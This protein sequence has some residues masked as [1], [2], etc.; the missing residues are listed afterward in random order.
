LSLLAAAYD[1][2]ARGGRL[3][4]KGSATIIDAAYNELVYGGQLIAIGAASIAATCSIVLGRSPPL[5]LL[6]IVYLFA[7]AAYTVNKV[8]ETGQDSI[9][10]PERTAYV[11]KRSGFLRSIVP[12]FFLLGL[13]LALL[14]SLLLFLVLL[15]PIVLTVLY[16]IGSDRLVKITGARRF[17]DKLIV[18]NV[19]TSF[20]WA[21][22]PLIA[23]LYFP[24]ISLAPLLIAPFVF[25]RLLS[26]TVFFDIRDIEADTSFGTR[27]IPVVYGVGAANVFMQAADVAAFCYILLVALLG[28]VPYFTLA[29]VVFPVYSFAYRYLA[30]FVDKDVIRDLIADAE[31]VLW[32]PAI[33]LAKI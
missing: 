33:Y 4:N 8:T 24:Q 6:L 2:L 10:H 29:L 19:T 16:S 23:C 28:L 17:K 27:T 13:I 1:G 14:R 20:G 26:N 32:A 12:L 11:S 5:G 3:I 9:S 25:L 30:A 21:I 15:S 7:H 31:Y 18:K 22:I